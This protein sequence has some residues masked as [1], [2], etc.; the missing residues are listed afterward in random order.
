LGIAF[1][2][3]GIN[4]LLGLNHVYWS[5]ADAEDGL[6]LTIS[7]GISSIIIFM[8]NSLLT[9]NPDLLP[10]PPLPP[11]M[12]VLFSS[13]IM[14]ASLAIRFRLRL[15][16]SVASRWL[17]WRKENTGFGE[18]VLIL[19]GGEGGEIVNMLMQHG[20]ISKLFSIIGIVDDDPA[21]RGMRINHTWVLGSTNELTTLIQKHDIRIVM[22]AITNISHDAR[23]RI[24][25]L[26]KRS[27]VRLIYLSDIL[28]AIQTQLSE[29]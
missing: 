8:L 15:I 12:I 25:K 9:H 2:F 27:D 26:C 1:F 24:V 17:T 11:E 3:S 23:E 22:F 5:R 4:V 6:I 29:G 18:R 10:L 14:L 19:G 16:T 13:F 7:N 28:G 21:K 20:P